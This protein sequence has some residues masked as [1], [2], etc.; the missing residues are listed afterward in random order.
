MHLIR[1]MALMQG[2]SFHAKGPFEC[3]KIP[4]RSSFHRRVMHV[5]GT[6]Q[7]TLKFRRLTHCVDHP[8]SDCNLKRQKLMGRLFLMMAL[9]GCVVFVGETHGLHSLKL[10]A[11]SPLKMGKKKQK[12][13]S[14]NHPFSGVNSVSFRE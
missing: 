11:S 7:C 9:Q 8:E 14:S 1:S 5:S 3:L 13:F 4:Q 12:E 10:T 2:G 6:F